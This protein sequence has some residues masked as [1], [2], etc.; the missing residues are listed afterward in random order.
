MG[1]ERLARVRAAGLQH[2]RALNHD[3]TDL[4]STHSGLALTYRVELQ[5]AV[6]QGYSTI[7]RSVALRPNV[8]G[9]YISSTFVG[10]TTKVPGVVARA[11]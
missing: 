7:T 2:A 3:N 6:G 9:A 1:R 11:T 5:F 4:Q 8:S 10:G